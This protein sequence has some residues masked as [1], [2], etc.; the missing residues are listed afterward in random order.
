MSKYQKYF[1]MNVI[2][3]IIIS[4]FYSENITASVNT[5][6]PGAVFREYKWNG[7]WVN[8]GK[9]QRVTNPIAES[10]GAKE[11]LPNP[12]NSIVIDDLDKAV[13]A[14]VYIENLQCHAGT[15]NKRIRMNKNRWL[16]IPEAVD[17]PVDRPEKYQTMRY[18]VVDIPLKHI[19]KGKNSFELTVDG[20]IGHETGWGQILVYGITF[21]IYYSESKKHPTGRITAP[22]SGDKINENPVLSASVSGGAGIK[23]VDFIGCYE[24]FNYAGDN[25]WRQWQYIYHYGEI[26]HHIGTA[27]K[28]PYSVTWNTEYLPDQS[29]PVKIMARIMDKKGMCYLTD[30]VDNVTF[31]RTGR[32]VKLYKPY[33]IPEKWATRAE[34]THSCK[35]DVPDDLSDAV[36]AKMILSNWNGQHA[37]VI[38]INRQKI[39]GKTGLDHDISYEEIDVP[40]RFIKT[41]TNTIHTYSSTVH[42]GIEVNWPGPVL[43]IAFSGK[44]PQ[45]PEQFE[46]LN[47]KW[48]H[49][50]SVSGDLPLPTATGTQQTSSLVLDV[51]K[52]GIN[53]FIITDRSVDDAVVWFRH[54]KDGWERYVIENRKTRVE[55][56]SACCDID[57][58]GDLDIIFGG[59]GGSNEVWW[60]ENPCP[61]YDKNIPWKRYTIK[62]SGGNKQHDQMIGDFDGD[63]EDEL[64]FWNQGSNCL[65]FSEIP[66]NPKQKELWNCIPIY[67]YSSDSE[68]KQRGHKYYPRWKRKNE[69]EGLAKAD[70]DGDGK[71]DIVG[72]GRWFKH[73]EG[74]KFIEN[75]IDAGYAFSRSAAGQLIEGGRPEVILVVGDGIAPMMLYE[76]QEG[77]WMPKELL[78]DVD[79]G[80]SL[81]II[82]F[83]GDGHLDI[84]CG[85]MRL[86]NGNPDAKTWILFGDGKGNFRKKV[87]TEGFAHHESRIV[88]LDGDGDLDILEK[89]YQW[90][91]PRVDVW[92][93]EGPEK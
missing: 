16:R 21:R 68:M 77:T 80:H 46:K 35:V 53:D 87:V 71:I 67:S 30:A 6:S 89:P 51:D 1:N 2:F 58:D 70:M 54:V 85:E 24:D 93:N 25:I 43:K 44:K 82:D 17:I 92:L 49:L 29:K 26:Q 76:W 5:F 59:D 65:Y 45:Q 78:K 32:S 41:G 9:W 36:G 66:E 14:E 39:I 48:T 83:D 91:A 90:G 63:G 64:V 12:V 10:K 38:G 27:L 34:K 15:Q 56:G 52:D 47:Y 40:L 88:D 61:D 19:K 7:P 28:R 74:T 4:V 73:V 23:Q 20:T 31:V 79:N 69:H 84:F 22:S 57:K 86:G 60:W 18:A 33:D 75:I 42:H 37:E 8:A 13:R 55:A 81:A 3:F 50:S 72:A 11:F 62:A